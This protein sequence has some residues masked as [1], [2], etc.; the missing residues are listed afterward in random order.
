MVN[1]MAYLKT[2]V[3]AATHLAATASFNN[4][5]DELA[6]AFNIIS[7]NHVKS[8]YNDDERRLLRID[9]PARINLHRR[10]QHSTSR[11]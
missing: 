3:V 1:Q 6:V 2:N 4:I 9:V 10:F 5:Y 11:R 7:G 8:I